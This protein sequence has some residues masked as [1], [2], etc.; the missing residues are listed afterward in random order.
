LLYES[1]DQP[2]G[3]VPDLELEDL[4]RRGTITGDMLVWHEGMAD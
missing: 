1:E 3:P 4:F 2:V